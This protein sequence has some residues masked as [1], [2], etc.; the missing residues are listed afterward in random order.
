MKSSATAWPITATLGGKNHWKVL[1]KD[2][3]YKL[4]DLF[5]F[6]QLE[7]R[8]AHYQHAF[9]QSRIKEEII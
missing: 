3:Q 8:I 2:C 1:N 6:N 5:N 4:H 9:F 7:T